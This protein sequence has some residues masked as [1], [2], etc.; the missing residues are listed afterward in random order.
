MTRRLSVFIYASSNNCFCPFLE[1][2][3][4]PCE[5]LWGGRTVYEW[6]DHGHGHGHGHPWSLYLCVSWVCHCNESWLSCLHPR[7]PLLPSVQTTLSIHSRISFHEHFDTFEFLS[8]GKELA[9]VKARRK[10]SVAFSC[11]F[12]FFT[13]RLHKSLV[14]RCVQTYHLICLGHSTFGLV[15]WTII[16]VNEFNLKGPKIRV[17]FK[18][19]TTGFRNKNNWNPNLSLSTLTTTT[20]R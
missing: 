19:D 3:S 17:L 8:Y 16:N 7:S 13:I 15:C 10:K 11:W 4:H 20:D 2:K 18:R 1:N 5:C 6:S 9:N 14:D 12:S